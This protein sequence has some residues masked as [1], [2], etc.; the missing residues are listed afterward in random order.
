MA[1][2][3]IILATAPVVVEG[4]AAFS[5]RIESA[6]EVRGMELD[7]LPGCAVLDCSRIGQEAWVWVDGS[8]FGPFRVVDCA[9][10]HHRAFWDEHDR[11]VDLP[12]SLWDE[13]G[14]PLAPYPVKVYF[15]GVP[16]PH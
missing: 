4:D 14:L 15:P 8:W 3:T 13:W 5:Y 11:A 9:A 6:A 7:G 16:P 2:L 10:S 12:W 1:L